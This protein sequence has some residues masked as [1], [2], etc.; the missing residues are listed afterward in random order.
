MED[1]RQNKIVVK[2]RKT[3]TLLGR[4]RYR[5][6]DFSYGEWIIFENGEPKYYLNIFDDRYSHI[7]GRSVEAYLTE[8]FRKKGL[9]LSFK[10]NAFGLPIH[11]KSEVVD[12][13]LERLPVSYV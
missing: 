6:S 11:S 5:L 7:K 10:D 12:L 8:Q 3:P 2:V 13:P 1:L 9:K 4:N